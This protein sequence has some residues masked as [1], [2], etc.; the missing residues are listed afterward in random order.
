MEHAIALDPEHTLALTRLVGNRC[1][2]RLTHGEE[3]VQTRDLLHRVSQGA[4]ECPHVRDAPGT[5]SHR[6][7]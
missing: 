2:M 1:R 5:L 7:G 3:G 4:G 6:S